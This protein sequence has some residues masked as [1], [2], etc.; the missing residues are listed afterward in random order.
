MNYALSDYTMEE[1]QQRKAVLEANLEEVTNEICSRRRLELS[2]DLAQRLE[3]IFEEAE[4]SGI[5]IFLQNHYS[6]F[7][8]DPSAPDFKDDCVKIRTLLP[9]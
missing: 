6:A 3:E 2:N 1:L 4:E 7:H 9:N 8:F 5:E